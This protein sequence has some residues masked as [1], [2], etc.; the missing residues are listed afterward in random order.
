MNDSEHSFFRS[1]FYEACL[2]SGS[3]DVEM[4]ALTMVMAV[5]RRCCTFIDSCS[6]G[7]GFTLWLLTLS[8]FCLSIF[9]FKCSSAS[10]KTFLQ[11]VIYLSH[12]RKWER[13]HQLYWFY[14]KK[15][16]I[17]SST[18]ISLFLT[19]NEQHR[20]AFLGDYKT[21]KQLKKVD[22]ETVTPNQIFVDNLLGWM[23]RDFKLKN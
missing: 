22:N 17:C 8:D 19:H 20:F 5:E 14:T 1:E 18:W 2:L 9:S 21:I 11:V 13:T 10:S 12:F 3:R 6:L 4:L 23:T 7:N 16:E 15:N